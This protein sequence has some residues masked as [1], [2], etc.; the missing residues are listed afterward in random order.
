MKTTLPPMPRMAVGAVALVSYL[1]APFWD[2]AQATTV[3]ETLPLGFSVALGTATNL[4]SA[5]SVRFSNPMGDEQLQA[6]IWPAYGV[7]QKP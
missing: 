4:V 2:T 1:A 5:G 3:P 7:H 6:P